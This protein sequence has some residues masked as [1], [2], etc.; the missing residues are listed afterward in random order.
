ML[1]ERR[2][3]A[4]LASAPGAAGVAV[5]RVSGPES[6][7]L[8]R[9]CFSHRGDYEPRRLYLGQVLLA[10]RSVEQAMAVFFRAPMSYTGED[11][12]ELHCH[13]GQEPVRATLEALFAAGASPAEPGEFTRRAFLNGK[14]DLSQAE[15]VMD[16]ISARAEGA[17]RLA[18][19]QLEGRLGRAVQKLADDLLLLLAEV[20]V[21]ADYPEEDLEEQTAARCAERLT[22]AAQ[23]LDRLLATVRA[24]RTVREGLRC[25]IVGRPNAGKSSLLNALLSEDRAIVTAR[26]GTTRDTLDAE[27]DLD[28]LAVT[29]VDTAGIR[30]SH[31]EIERLGVERARRQLETADIALLVVDGAEGITDDDRRIAAVCAGLPFI[32]VLNKADLPQAVTSPQAE[33]LG[34]PHALA[35]SALTGQGVEA[36]RALLHRLAMGSEGL[37]ESA[38]LANLRHIDCARQA[39]Q[40]LAD[41]LEGIS[42]GFPPDTA[43]ADIRRA[44][45]ALG[46]ITGSTV[47]EDVIDL[48]FSRFCLGK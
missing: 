47:D 43:A 39:R 48:I 25:A 13:G 1:D 10:G 34:T 21:T 20:E 11:A 41:A 16:L 35:L 7:E 2:T 15:A 29:F 40:A 6:L 26:P 3:I 24:G 5:I 14:L 19:R 37:G 28:G 18:L 4:A 8:L 27:A 17:H 46:Q 9:R 32:A 44:W 22:A 23:A 45:H 38:V 12:A 31:D 30:E 42:A 36:L 33:D